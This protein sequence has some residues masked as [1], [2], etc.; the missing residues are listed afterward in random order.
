MK[1]YLSLIF[2]FTTFTE[3]QLDT[4]KI[5]EAR[6]FLY[7][8]DIYHYPYVIDK[9]NGVIKKAPIEQ[10]LHFYVFD[11]EIDSPLR[12]TKFLLFHT[13]RMDPRP[14]YLIASYRDT[15]HLVYDSWC[16]NSY[17]C[18]SLVEF[19]NQHLLD[20]ETLQTQQVTELAAT[21]GK[22]SF[23]NNKIVSNSDEVWFRDYRN[24]VVHLPD[25]LKGLVK[26]LL[27]E[28][29]CD[30]IVLEFFV[31]NIYRLEKITLWYRKKQIEVNSKVIWKSGYQPIGG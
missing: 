28:T 21:L 19:I 11:L 12:N 31:W 5:E 27:T 4:L 2:L 6:R 20:E 15:F 23:P 18:N 9:I 29:T 17:G 26:P 13:T 24:I 10:G 14:Y 3:A 25:S 8:H 7:S 30:S 1:F 16:A 22:L